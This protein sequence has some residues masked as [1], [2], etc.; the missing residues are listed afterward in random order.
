VEQLEELQA[1]FQTSLCEN[2][3]IKCNILAHNKTQVTN[4]ILTHHFKDTEHLIYCEKE[5]N[6]RGN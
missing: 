4:Q 2:K 6:T 1:D 3:G 5:Q